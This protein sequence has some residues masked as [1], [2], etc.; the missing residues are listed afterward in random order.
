MKK[1]LQ[2]TGLGDNCSLCLDA[3]GRKPA[4]KP[5]FVVGTE[6]GL[7]WH[8]CGPHLGALVKASNGEGNGPVAPKPEARPEPRPE[9]RTATPVTPA[10]PAVAA[11]GPK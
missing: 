10:A 5:V 1:K 9:P 4:S 11:N 3:D 2:I 6:D 8:V 7:T